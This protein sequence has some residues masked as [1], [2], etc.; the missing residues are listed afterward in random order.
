MLVLCPCREG[1]LELVDPIIA[2]LAAGAVAGLSGLATQAVE[3]AYARLKAALGARFPQLDLHVQALEA[4]PDSESRQ[5]SL[6]ESWS[7]PA[8]SVTSSC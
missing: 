6:A 7:R 1:G 8:L 3:D 4:R 2:A 5:S